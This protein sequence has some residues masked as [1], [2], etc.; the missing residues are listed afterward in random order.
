MFKL[1]ATLPFALL[2]SLKKAISK[3][4]LAPI[5]LPKALLH[6]MV[7]TTD[8]TS[9]GVGGEAVS[10]SHNG[11]AAAGLAVPETGS[12]VEDMN[13]TLIHPADLFKFAF[14]ANVSHADH[15]LF[16]ALAVNG[17]SGPLEI[18]TKGILNCNVS[19]IMSSVPEVSYTVWRGG[20][21]GDQKWR[22]NM[23]HPL[24]HPWSAVDCR[25]S[26]HRLPDTPFRSYYLSSPPA[27]PSVFVSPSPTTVQLNKWIAAKLHGSGNVS[28]IGS[29]INATFPLCA[30]RCCR[31]ENHKDTALVL[32][33][34]VCSNGTAMN[35]LLGLCVGG[36]MGYSPCPGNFTRCPLPSGV[37]LCLAETTVWGMDS[38]KVAGIL[39][40]NLPKQ[41]CPMN[42]TEAAYLQKRRR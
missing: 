13:S 16:K 39:M 26:H 7:N 38:C 11:T 33:T 4:V 22:Q 8:I 12:G 25:M 9:D 24:V 10:F 27:S 6:S 23:L 14:G 30:S 40:H 34:A 31:Q 15:G 37:P 36:E 5:V 3:A 29:A 19:D 21:R 17:S 20:G 28:H 41:Q 32:P 35:N 42:V 18:V 1:K 2:P